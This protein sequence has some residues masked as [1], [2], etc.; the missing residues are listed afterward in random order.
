[1]WGAPSPHGEGLEVGVCD[2]N[3]MGSVTEIRLVV[4]KR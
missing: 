3:D 2:L 1:M 4:R